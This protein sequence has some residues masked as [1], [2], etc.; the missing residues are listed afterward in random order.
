MPGQSRASGEAPGHRR[1]GA[2][3]G[4]VAVVVA[5]VAATGAVAGSIADS[6]S[7]GTAHARDWRD[8][9]AAIGPLEQYGR[10][11]GHVFRQERDY[12]AYVR[13][14]GGTVAPA[15]FPQRMV[16]LF[17]AGPRSTPAYRLGIVGV[18][19]RRHAV[20]VALRERTPAADDPAPSR[21]TFPYRAISIPWS[22]KP[23]TIDWL[24]RP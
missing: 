20:V 5:V 18:T 16:V 13:A 21:L 1:S 17:A 3:A 22:A 23:V 14:H 24:G 15:G 4:R 19:E 7:G 2:S 6:R 9:T 12:A 11:T 10:P 8:L